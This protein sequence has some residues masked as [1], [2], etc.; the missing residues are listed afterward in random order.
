MTIVAP[1][2]DFRAGA[3]ACNHLQ[4]LQAG[5]AQLVDDQLTHL[6][7][8]HEHGTHTRKIALNIA[9]DLRGTRRHR[10]RP[11]ADRRFGSNTF[12]RRIGG[13]DHRT[14]PAADMFMRRCDTH[15]IAKLSCHLRFPHD[16]AFERCGD[17]KQVNERC[18]ALIEIRLAFQAFFIETAKLGQ[19]ADRAL[20]RRAAIVRKPEYLGTGTGGHGHRLGK[21]CLGDSFQKPGKIVFGDKKPVARRLGA[22]P[23]TGTNNDE[24]AENPLVCHWIVSCA[25]SSCRKNR[26]QPIRRNG[27]ARPSASG[28]APLRRRPGV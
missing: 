13:L 24:T 16:G 11:L 8:G 7:P 10:Y 20:A 18:F 4:A 22:C 12:R 25:A 27:E 15:R 26:D 17:P 23:V 5:G 3:A 14:Q 21:T 6:S 28:R 19:Q 2:A 1:R 9:G